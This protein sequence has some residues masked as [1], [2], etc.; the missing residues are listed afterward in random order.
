MTTLRRFLVLQAFAAWQGGFLFYAA[1]VVPTGTDVLESPTLQGAITR[2]V[3][4]WLNLIG[5]VWAG[6]F[7]WDLLTDRDPVAGRR[8]LRWVGWVLAVEL[9]V[10]LAVLH[11]KLDRL[12]DEN[13]QRAD[14][15]AFR[16]FHVAYLWAST[17]QWLT[18]LYLAWLTLAAWRAADRRD[19]DNDDGRFRL[20]WPATL[21]G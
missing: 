14:R 2:P 15:A 12:F 9:L 1:V 16:R 5:V 4:N 11:L 21:A 6:V 10:M 8:R 7:L 3:T 19:D 18:A 13:G 17:A 20:R